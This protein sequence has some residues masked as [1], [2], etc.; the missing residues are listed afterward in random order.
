MFMFA[1]LNSLQKWLIQKLG[2][3]SKDATEKCTTY[4]AK[5]LC[6]IAMH[7]ELQ[8]QKKILEKV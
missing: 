3:E 2:F 8:T 7:K 4:I 5:E 1:L 6:I